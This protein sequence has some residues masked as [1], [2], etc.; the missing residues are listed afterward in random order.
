[1]R[2]ASQF[3]T[4]IAN[5]PWL[6]GIFA[7]TTASVTIFSILPIVSVLKQSLVGSEGFNGAAALKTFGSE[8]IWRTLANTLL[9]GV[10]SAAIATM[11]GFVLA[12][13]QTRT[14]MAGKTFIHFIS[15]LPVIS[16][17]FIM[18]LAI[19]TLFGRSGLITRELLGIRNS[20]VYGFPSLVAIQ[21]LAFSP[22]AY[23]NIRGMLQSLD[24]AL[25]DASL[26]LGAT[27]WMTFSR[28]VLPL[29]TPAIFSSALLVFVKSIEDFGNPMIIGGSYTTLAVEA[30]SQMIGYFN[31]QVGA[32]LASILLVPSML[33]F[34]VHRYWINKRSYVTV[35]GKPTVQTIRLSNRSVV[36]PLTAVCYLL[37]AI[38][39]LFYATVVYVSFMKLPGADASLTLQHYRTVFTA[40]FQT[41]WNSLLLATI[42]T[43][44]T[45]VGGMFIAYLLARRVFPGTF[46]LR[47]GTLL[48]FATPGTI[49]GIGF[50]S[51]FNTPPLLLT[52]TAFIIVAAM[53]VK[54]LQVGI[55]AGSNQLKQIDKSLEEASIILGA[56]NPRTLF[57]V[58]LPL[59][60]PAM[61]ASAAYAFTRSLTTLSAVIFLVSA[62][63]TLVT[64]TILSHVETQKLGLA[65]A[66]CVILILVV[67]VILAIMQIALAPTARRA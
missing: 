39:I 6:V 57:I 7:L 29:C 21:V 66:Y 24:S 61:F 18:A 10:T 22:I 55:E 11:T 51:V 46:L 45:A 60:R 59:L 67:L 14:T 9:L 53:V 44:V 27:Q 12:F 64:V 23:L 34:M 48:S 54:N 35:T 42:A 25:E 13:S 28:V 8:Y 20:N 3:V 5:D 65:A 16:P 15:V 19:V 33:A 26:S 32:L 2:I 38:I 62:N 41:L 30:Y 63:W 1:M 40:G 43:P 37:A 4:R 36:W 47:W 58:T 52:G 31:L 50:V 49:L 17:P 56:S